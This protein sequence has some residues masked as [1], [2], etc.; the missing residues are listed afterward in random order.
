MADE[1]VTDV[2]TKIMQD[3][4][5]LGYLLNVDPAVAWLVVDAVNPDHPFDA[6]TFQAK[7]MQTDWWKTTTDAQR[8]W[9]KL[10]AT[11]PASAQQQRDQWRAHLDEEATKMGVQLKPADLD[12]WTEHYLPKGVASD[13]PTIL[14]ELARVY[15]TRTDLRTGVGS[16]D[17]V[18]DQMRQI[19]SNYFRDLTSADLDWWGAQITSGQ[20]TIQNFQTVIQNQARDRFPTFRDEINSGVT[21]Q[22]LFA[23][24]RDAIAKT[25]EIDPSTIDLAHDP[26][27]SK[28]LGVAQPDGTFRPMTYSESLQLAREQPEWRNT[29]NGKQSSDDLAQSL[30]TELG[31]AKF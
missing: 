29:V 24:Q 14:N 30:L 12:W 4:P 25:L 3:Y 23:N 17:T 22:Q 1:P 27:W 16:V 11:D 31:A 18:K 21:P 2:Y 15:Q 13:D 26:R 28:I 20:Q 8:S 19:A 5:T 10:S 7:L 9:E 6:A